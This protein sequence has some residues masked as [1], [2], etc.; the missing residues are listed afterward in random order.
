MKNYHNIFNRCFKYLWNSF[1]GFLWSEVIQSEIKS[2]PSLCMFSFVSILCNIRFVLLSH[3]IN[4]R[5]TSN[6]FLIKPFS[7]RKKGQPVHQA[8]ATGLRELDVC[9]LTN[10]SEE[11][12]STVW[13]HHL[14]VTMEKPYCCTWGCGRVFEFLLP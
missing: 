12:V 3:E 10:A 11:I 5:F 8:P 1:L 14:Q 6:F 13:A 2:C 7:T 9:N 4:P